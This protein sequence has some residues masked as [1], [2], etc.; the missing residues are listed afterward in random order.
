MGRRPG[1]TMEMAARLKALER[2]NCQPR[3]SNEMLRKASGHF[4]QAELGR[5]LER[6]VFDWNRDSETV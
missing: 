6:A 2:E 4:T 5:R 1:P 3:Q